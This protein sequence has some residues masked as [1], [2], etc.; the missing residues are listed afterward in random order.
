MAQAIIDPRGFVDVEPSMVGNS[1]VVRDGSKTGVAVFPGTDVC[2][3]ALQKKIPTKQ[4]IVNIFP[5]RV[6]I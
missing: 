2:E 1:P 6:F 4:M 5:D 3:Q